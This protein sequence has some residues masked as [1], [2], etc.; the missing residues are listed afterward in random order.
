MT[1][2]RDADTPSK[3]ATL[4]QEFE[5]AF[6]ATSSLLANLDGYTRPHLALL[7]RPIMG[8]WSGV[9]HDVGSA[10]GGLWEVSVW[11]EWRTKLEPVFP[12][13]PTSPKDAKVEDF[14]AFFKPESGILWSFFKDN[15]EGQ[16]RRTGDQFVPSRRFDTKVDF[17][18]DLL[19]NCLARGAK[20]ADA[21]FGEREA[22]ALEFQVNLHSVSPNVSEVTLSLDRGRGDVPQHAGGMA[23][24]RVAIQRRRPG[25]ARAH[26]WR[27]WPRRRNHSRRRIWPTSAA[28]GCQRGRSGNRRRRPRP[29]HRRSL[30]LSISR[31]E[32]ATLKLDVRS[33]QGLE[34]LSPDLI[35]DYK[36]PR[37]I[38]VPTN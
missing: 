27:C 5:T 2:L 11:E 33:N 19:N 17:S 14:E 32:K 9:S 3:T 35:R 15:L 23:A 8:A 34:M 38:T 36:C 6:R 1:D 25:R 12:F 13:T 31:S 28:R 37:I 26:S 21:F 30:R 29:A 16:I 7:L 24:R 10:A 20:I 22:L 4:E 18:G